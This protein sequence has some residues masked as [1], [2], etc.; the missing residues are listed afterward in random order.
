MFLGEDVRGL[1]ARALPK[2]RRGDAVADL[3]QCTRFL[4]GRLLEVR[5]FGRGVLI[6]LE[7]EVSEGTRYGPA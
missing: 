4:S 7:P 5:L 3:G 2:R 1:A 6:L